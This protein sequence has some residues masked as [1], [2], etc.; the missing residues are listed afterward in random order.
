[1]TE[2]KYA[3]MILYG[4]KSNR[5]F[6]SAG[7]IVSKNPWMLSYKECKRITTVYNNDPDVIIVG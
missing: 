5:I 6:L 3:I 2:Q 4:N 7:G 1:M